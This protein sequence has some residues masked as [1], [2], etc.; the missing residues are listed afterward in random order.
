MPKCEI[1]NQELTNTDID[2][3]EDCY[4]YEMNRD[5]Y[6]NYTEN[7]YSELY[8]ENHGNYRI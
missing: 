8:D 3:C 5:Y 2:I 4:D 7:Y 1:C 6:E